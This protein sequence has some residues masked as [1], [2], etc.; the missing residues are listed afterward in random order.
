MWDP[1]RPKYREE[2]KNQNIWQ[3]KNKKTERLGRGT[4]NTCEKIEGLS[5][6]NG[7]DIGL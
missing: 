7:V 3:K 2:N 5:P 4:L 6:K 1:S